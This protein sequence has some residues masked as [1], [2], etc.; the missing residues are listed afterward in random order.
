VTAELPQEL[1]DLVESGPLTYVSTI[2]ADGS[3]QVTAIWIGFDGDNLISTHMRFN[4]KLRNM[5]RDPRV[6]LSFAPH[7]QP[8][9][10]M[11]PHAIVYATASV[12]PLDLTGPLLTRL[13]KA[14]V[15]PD[16]EYPDQSQTGYIVR[17]SIDRIGGVGPWA[18]G[19]N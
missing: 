5:Q 11:S 17:Y 9:D 2:N 4:A 7:Q 19:A 18:R 8:G 1:R 16:A 6:V 10:W 13:A 3:P 14:Y 12:G 15:G